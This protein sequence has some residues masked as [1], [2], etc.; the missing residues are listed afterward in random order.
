MGVLPDG[1]LYH[2][3]YLIAY[4]ATWYRTTAFTCRAG[5]KERDVSKNRNAG[6]V[7]CNAL[8]CPAPNS[9]E[10]LLAKLRTIVKRLPDAIKIPN[11]SQCRLQGL[12]VPSADKPIG[13]I[14]RGP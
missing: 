12:G 7:K 9:V 14:V 1:D 10:D 2:P 5:C 4:M 11:G 3:R 6:P 8:L 13:L